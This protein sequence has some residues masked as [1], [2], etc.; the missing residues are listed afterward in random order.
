[1]TSRR[2]HTALSLLLLNTILFLSYSLLGKLP[3]LLFTSV[4]PFWPPAALSVLAAML[5]GWR[6]MPAIF[7]GS[8]WV[9]TDLF[10]W[11]LA[12]ASW[13][14]LGNVLAPMA[15]Y[16]GL[17]RH[18]TA[19]QAFWTS[20]AAISRFLFWMGAVAGLLSGLFGALGLVGLEGQ[21]NALFVP[22]LWQWAV[23]DACAALMLVPV[24]HLLW[25]QRHS[26]VSWW[27]LLLQPEGLAALAFSVLVWGLAFFAP[28]LSLP[29]RL[30]LLAMLLLPP[31]WSVFRLDQR[32]TLLHLAVAFILV[33]GATISGYGPYA[34]LPLA[35]AVVGIELMGMAMAASILYAGA[36]HNQRQQAL[37]ELR[38]LNLHLERRAE[39]RAQELLR[40]ERI[41]RDMIERLP[42]PTVI[43]DPATAQVLYANPAARELF[44]SG[45]ANPI[46]M[47]TLEQW[48]DPDTRQSLLAEVKRSHAVQNR[49]IAFRRL[50]GSIIWV[51]ASVIETHFDQTDALLFAFKDIT[52]QVQREKILQSQAQTDALTGVPNRRHFMAQAAQRLH[53]LAAQGL[54][55]A[56]VLFD[57]DDFKQIN[58]TRGHACG[59][60]VLQQVASLLN[61]KK[62]PQ[63]V[64][65]RLGGEEF[66]LLLS[67]VSAEQALE[68]ADA[69]RRELDGL[70]QVCPDGQVIALPTCSIG[71]AWTQPEP[72]VPDALLAALMER[73]D[74]ALYDAKSGGKNRSVLSDAPARSVERS[75]RS[76][77]AL[78]RQAQSL[79]PL[80]LLHA[81]AAEVHFGRFFERAAQA[82]AHL[83]G[84]DG[85]AFIERDGDMLSYRFFH[86]LPDSHQQ[87]FAAHR[88]PADE[89]TAG[90]V[91]REGRAF[92][93]ADYAASPGALPAFV[94]S[95]L[96]ANYLVPVRSGAQTLA[97]LAIAW[98][99]RHPTSEPDPEQAENIHLLAELMAG[100]LRRERLERKLRKRATRDALTRLPNRASLE[101]HL[102]RAVAR[103]RRQQQILAVGMLDLDDFKPVND[104][105]GHA[106][107]D[108]LLRSFAQR[109]QQSL[110]DTDFVGRLGGD[111]FVLVLE[112]LTQLTDL[113]ATLS[114]LHD[115]V[116]APFDL[117]D[118][119][120]ACVDMSLG[121]AL[122]PHHGADADTLIRAADAALY[123]SK[124][125]KAQRTTWWQLAGQHQ[126][127]IPPAAALLPAPIAPYGAD[128]Q[129][130]LRLLAPQVDAF[131]SGF[132]QQFYTGLAAQP[133]MQAILHTLSP[134]EQTRL[135]RAQE[136]HLLAL[137]SPDLEEAT[138]RGD[139][140][141][142]GAIHALTGVSTTVLVESLETY[143]QQAV[144]LIRHTLLRETDRQPLQRVITGRIRVE[145]QAQAQGEQETIDQYTNRIQ[146]ATQIATDFVNRIDFMHWVLEELVQLPGIQ[147]VAFGRP[148]AMGQPV[149][150]F[151]TPR[152][153]AYVAHFKRHG[154]AYL[155]TLESE[156]P[157]S[158]ATQIRA[159]RN[160]RIETVSSFSQDARA[161]PWREAAEV[162]GFRSAVSIPI[163]D[164]NDRMAAILTLYGAHPNQFESHWMLHSLTPLG[165]LFTR[166]L[167]HARRAPAQ[168]LPDQQRLA[169]RARLT[170]EGLDMLLQPLVDLRDGRVKRVEALAR[171]RLQDGKQVLPG[172]F[173]PWFGASEITRLFTLGLEKAIAQILALE[174]QGVRLELS[175]NLP[176]EVLMQPDCP[177]WIAR[178]L[179]RTRLS[180][181]RLHMELLESGDFHDAPRRDAAV[182][183]LSA[184]GVRLEM[185]DLGSGYS[186]LLR[187]RQL[188]FQTVKI[189]QGLVREAQKDPRRVIG[190]IGSLIRLAH[191]LELDVVV[192]GLESP[193][194]I[195]VAMVL[196]ADFGQGF[197]LA[198]PM[199]AAALSDWIRQFAITV[200]PAR[201][202]TAL[203]ALAAHWLWEYGGHDRDAA[204]PERAHEHCA[205]AHYLRMQSLTDGEVGH[206]HADMHRLAR[207]KGIN[208]AEYRAT[209]SQ[210]VTL[211]MNAPAGHAV[212]DAQM[213]SEIDAPI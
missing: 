145:L 38:V 63:D 134:T 139:A 193:A 55:A 7:L 80:S 60:R 78:R 62:R 51:L 186:S 212:G 159:W 35:Q 175:I 21:D 205:L 86:G 170:P 195:E 79:L 37:A 65:A 57:L 22:T 73:A 76:S 120:S 208:S 34:G 25:Q 179:E 10:H 46:G 102:A 11:S 118:G 189:D 151:A 116:Q 155:P 82:A 88:F 39:D 123:A 167:S 143:L 209:M 49:E 146:A 4:S 113:E 87:Q 23:G 119:H 9:N 141:R 150:E 191:T 210:M 70:I 33:L 45:Q 147:A 168:V 202:T 3:S 135:Y 111:E 58:D 174:A 26:A 105:W 201:P 93:H 74:T 50:D 61:E 176:P 92:F 177:N 98:F 101:Q 90:Q 41:F 131:A 171:L 17:R 109:L 206:V 172:E 188:P 137:L 19:E 199:P 112:G 99:S 128:A 28:G 5:W 68:L 127:P 129:R 194:L 183:A 166:A 108:A 136:A 84:A 156:S 89:G 121:L 47:S 71:V 198:R 36:L 27:R 192:E 117:P 165:Q 85:A 48:V 178:A 94:D 130:L 197:A 64:F 43:T 53:D 154:Q 180:P 106:A 115:V 107:G 190:F 163:R 181:D 124:T 29:V 104:Q 30:G 157:L 153:N 158:K 110:R 97:V 103:A 125:H 187:L 173:L 16:W 91:V 18:A 152:F 149:V 138:H 122:Y 13:V 95:G 144:S 31:I 161:H 2:V 75:A 96:K 200:D 12:G 204:D 211:L 100:A 14:S 169:W 6:A 81:L 42:A 213:H 132:V 52:E 67:D 8:L 59:D 207:D 32:I 148:D 40:K 162:V 160:E 66:C 182:Q 54:A 142:L 24:A 15:G 83:V 56:F 44:G 196:G 72:G 126:E 133:Q 140:R 184:L 77:P 1:M 185:D 164:D 203:G 114:R 20:P 69:M